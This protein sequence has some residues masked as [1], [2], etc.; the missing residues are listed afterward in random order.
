MLLSLSALSAG[1]ATFCL[2]QRS[3]LI[4]ELEE[5]KTKYSRAVNENEIF[6]ALRDHDEALKKIDK[7]APVFNITSLALTASTAALSYLWLKDRKALKSTSF[8]V[9]KKENPFVFHSD[10]PLEKLTYLEITGNGFI[11]TF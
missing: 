4:D 11:L 5:V 1:G 2:I 6:A 7:K 9:F 8:P 10:F 3:K